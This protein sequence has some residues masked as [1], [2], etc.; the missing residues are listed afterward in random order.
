MYGRNFSSSLLY[1]REREMIYDAQ[2]IQAENTIHTPPL[3][4]LR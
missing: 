4:D 2:N 1:R 3:L